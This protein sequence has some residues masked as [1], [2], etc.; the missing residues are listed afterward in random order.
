[1]QVFTDV[2]VDG[3]AQGALFKGHPQLG[4][5]LDFQGV[6]EGAKLDLAGFVPG[7]VPFAELLDK[8]IAQANA[9]AGVIEAN[10]A[11]GG[12]AGGQ[13]FDLPGR[14][15]FFQGEDF[16]GVLNVALPAQG[17]ADGEIAAA[18]EVY[19]QDDGEGGA[20]LPE[21]GRGGGGGVEALAG[22]DEVVGKEDGLDVEELAFEFLCPTFG[23][24]YGVAEF[25]DVDFEALSD[26]GVDVNEVAGPVGGRPLTLPS[27]GGEGGA[28]SPS[29]LPFPSPASGRGE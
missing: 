17:P 3:D 2:A 23:V 7:G 28:P 9:G 22:G 13:D 19:A 16:E 11:A 20:G 15:H 5:N 29:L 25:F 6:G 4:E 14:G 18:S 24:V 27:P 12:D 21:I 10:A 26:G 8:V 1:M